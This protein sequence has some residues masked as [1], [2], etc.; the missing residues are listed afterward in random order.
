MRLAQLY[1]QIGSHFSVKNAINKMYFG[2]PFPENCQKLL[3]LYE[4]DNSIAFSQAF[5][6]LYYSREICEQYNICVRTVSRDDFESSRYRDYSDID[7]ICFQSSFTMDEAELDGF[8]KKARF[9]SPNAR[10]VYFDWFA[11]LDL[12]LASLLNERVDCYVKKQVFSDLDRYRQPT[13]GD[14]NLMDYYGKMFGL[15]YPQQYF[16]VPEG[17]FRKLL[18]GPGFFTADFMLA[19]F[20]GAQPPLAGRQQSIDVHARLGANGSDWYTRMR[21][22]SLDAVS[23]IPGIETVTTTGIQQKKYLAELA[24]SK[25]CFSPF[26]YGEVCWRDYEAVMCGSLLFKPDMQHIRTEPNIFVNGE[27]YVALR[28][29]FSDLEEKVKYYLENESER[30]RI[31]QN[32]FEL[33]Q[34]YLAEKRFLKQMKPLFTLAATKAQL[35]RNMVA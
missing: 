25:I 3:F 30:Q 27:T 9:K 18:L 2:R 19:Q 14:T 12:R 34:S 7:I 4:S 23:A 6:F 21:K 33:V 5:P 35:S 32:A 29:D 28:W 31:T 8:I 15:E 13:M 20:H 17:F 24:D 1:A 10:L 26:G 11:P 16:P 22:L